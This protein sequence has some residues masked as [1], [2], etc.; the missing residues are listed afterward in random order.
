ME[1]FLLDIDNVLWAADDNFKD[2]TKFRNVKQHAYFSDKNWQHLLE[3]EVIFQEKDTG[4][5]IELY[6][7]CFLCGTEYIAK[8]HLKA[9]VV[10]KH[11]GGKYCHHNVVNCDQVC[12]IKRCG[13]NFGGEKIAYTEHI[14]DPTLHRVDEILEARQEP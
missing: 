14:K 8:S 2:W 5:K 10:K 13:K 11:F 9:H 1:N 6:T 4:R 7:S 12:P 3:T